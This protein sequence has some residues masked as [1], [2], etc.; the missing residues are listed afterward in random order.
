MAGFDLN[1]T[2]V[3]GDDQS[4]VAWLMQLFSQARNRRV[5]FEVQWEEAAALCWPDYR[6]SFAFGHNRPPGM[7][8]TEYQVDTS[9]SIASH[10]FMAICDAMIT[11]Y[12]MLWSYVKADNPYLMK[13]RGVKLY[14]KELTETLW[15]E[16]YRWES[17]FFSSNQTNWQ[18][19][20]VFGNM[21]MW[22]D[23]METKPGNQKPGIRYVAQ[24]PGE[25][26]VLRNYQGREDGHI[27]HFRW[28]ARQAYQ[29]WGDKIPVLLKAA[30][31]KNDLQL[32]DFLQFVLPNN[33]YDPLQ[34]FDPVKGKPWVSV[35]VSVAGYCI[36][37]KG[38][39]RSYPRAGSTYMIA[40]EEEYGRGPA[41]MV[42]PDLK[43]LNSEKA[44]YL[45]QGH[46]AVEPAYLI[47]DDG[48]NTLRTS[49]N[50]KNYGGI[51]PGGEVLAR[52]LETGQIQVT[53]EMMQQS[54]GAVNDAFLVSLWSLFGDEKTMQM[55]ARQVIE[56]AN[57]RGIFLGPT[58]GRQF[59]E[60]VGPM[61][62][63]E[64]DILSFQR[65]LPPMPPAVKEAKGEYQTVY[66]SPLAQAIMGQPIAGFMRLVEFAGQAA[67]MT[68]DP[69]L[70]DIFEFDEALPE[71]GEA[72]HV[73]IHWFAS[74]QK[75]QQKRQGRAQQAERDAQVKELPGKA[76]IIKA[77]AISDKAQAGQ[78]T[79]GTL[80]GTPAGGMPMMPGQTQPGGRAF[81][82]PGG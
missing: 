73:P 44:M 76:A 53:P 42:L 32:W 26:Y 75:M 9:G 58:L 14:Y 80:S 67:Q 2:G 18:A 5:N 50:A 24:A 40:P 45:R 3:P 37:E 27:R 81:G 51:G 31:D 34:I 65:K 47:N 68:G 63:R 41:Q 59:G 79:G 29:K 35:Y 52:P 43:T 30:L 64:L 22:I 78:N 39:F 13:Q 1:Y 82:Q 55:N 72:D 23:E 54:L 46:K 56:E 4:F 15:K 17:G 36:L 48:L 33:E 60:Y 69:G 10:R 66:C 62:D 25:I 19:L 11:P 38:G 74:P 77:Q 6:N 12:N 20:G 71:M 28:S 70:M 16:R 57:Q 7:K 49:P 21:G 8:Y 61:I